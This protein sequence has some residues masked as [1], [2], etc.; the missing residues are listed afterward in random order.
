MDDSSQDEMRPLR[1]KPT[2][3]VAPKSSMVTQTLLHCYALWYAKCCYSLIWMGIRD[4]EV[5]IVVF[6]ARRSTNVA[7]HTSSYLG[8]HRYH[9]KGT[10]L[11]RQSLTVCDV[12]LTSYHTILSD[13]TKSRH[14]Q[15]TSWFRIVLDEGMFLCSPSERCLRLMMA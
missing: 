13:S 4:Q 15:E 14:L 6:S 7:R 3:I 12:V 1:S 11:D 10:K 5:V 2:L 9:G 8:T